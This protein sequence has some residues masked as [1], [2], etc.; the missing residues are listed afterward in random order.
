MSTI[1]KDK[2]SRVINF[3][4]SLDNSNKESE[5]SLVWDTEKGIFGTSDLNILKK[6]F[7]KIGLEKTD[8]F[9]DLG[10]GDGRVCILASLFSKAVGIEFDKDLFEDSLK[11]AD[12]LGISDVEFINSDYESFDFSKASIIFSYADHFFSKEFINKLKKDFH[13]VFYVYQGVFTPEGLTKGP[14]IWIDG[15]PIIS[16]YFD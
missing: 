12:I 4:E 10:S 6:F 16:Y 7:E 11:N 15:I 2:L 14:T 8:Y 13:G 1:I 3:F 9:V 5:K